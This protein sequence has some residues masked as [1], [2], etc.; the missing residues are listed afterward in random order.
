MYAGTAMFLSSPFDLAHIQ[1]IG[2][3]CAQSIQKKVPIYQLIIRRNQQKMPGTICKH[4]AIVRNS[5]F[6]LQKSSEFHAKFFTCV[7]TTNDSKS[8]FVRSENLLLEN[9]SS[10]CTSYCSAHGA[11]NK[12]RPNPWRCRPNA[13]HR[14]Q[15]PC[16]QLVHAASGYYQ[17]PK[18]RLKSQQM[19]QSTANHQINIFFPPEFTF[20]QF[21]VNALRMHHIDECL[22]GS[23][24]V[25]RFI[26]IYG[27]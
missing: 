1:H 17:M 26:G 4:R 10:N 6:Y 7:R 9:C 21:V 18:Y 5:F 25:G 19:W 23:V 8:V 22:Q 20:I 3:A 13:E 12:C 24:P 27:E 2:R 16:N 15:Y 14:G 11:S